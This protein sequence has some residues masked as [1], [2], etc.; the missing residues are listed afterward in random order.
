MHFEDPYDLIIK[1]KRL[2]YD[3]VSLPLKIDRYHVRNYNF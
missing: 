3:Y 2:F 1:E